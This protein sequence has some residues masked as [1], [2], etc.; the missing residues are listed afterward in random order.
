MQHSHRRRRRST[1]FTLVIDTDK[2]GHGFTARCTC[3]SLIQR[4]RGCVTPEALGY[5]QQ[6]ATHQFRLHCQ[7]KHVAKKEEV[8]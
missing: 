6:V 5:A 4:S 2:D 8:T 1:G 7:R 3:G